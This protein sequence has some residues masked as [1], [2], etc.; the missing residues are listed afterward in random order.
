MKPNTQWMTMRYFLKDGTFCQ[1]K[2]CGVHWELHVQQ[3]FG[4]G[5]SN[6]QCCALNRCLHFFNGEHSR[7]IRNQQSRF[8]WSTGSH[9]SVRLTLQIE[10]WFG[11]TGKGL[12]WLSWMLFHPLWWLIPDQLFH[13]NGPIAVSKLAGGCWVQVK[14][15]E[16]IHA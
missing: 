2:Q 8:H 6:W 15:K 12:A 1:G 13:P 5:C 11:V 4:G 9:G 3:L 7:T 14:P 10:M 16:T